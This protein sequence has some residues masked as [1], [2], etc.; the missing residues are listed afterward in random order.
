ML[1]SLRVPYVDM[2]R[3][4]RSPVG[5]T[6]TVA[7]SALRCTSCRRGFSRP[8]HLAR[9]EGVHTKSCPY[10]CSLCGRAFS[11]RDVSLRR[12]NHVHYL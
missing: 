1:S 8:D 10:R 12:L 5:Q 4:P 11:G 7:H 2:S 9:Y 3:V 6:H